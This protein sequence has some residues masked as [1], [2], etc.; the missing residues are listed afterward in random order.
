MEMGWFVILLAAIIA[1][2]IALRFIVYTLLVKFSR[3]LP[4][5]ATRIANIT[6]CAAG[7]VGLIAICGRALLSGH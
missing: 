3:Q 2:A 7:A 4:E 6:S 5:K 1:T